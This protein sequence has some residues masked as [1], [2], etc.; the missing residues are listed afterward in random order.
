MTTYLNQVISGRNFHALK[1]IA[2]QT[3]QGPAC[4]VLEEVAYDVV[5]K[6]IIYLFLE[7]IPVGAPAG[8]N[9]LAYVGQTARETYDRWRRHSHKADQIVAL[10]QPIGLTLDKA[11][12]TV[13]GWM[14]DF[15]GKGPQKGPLGGLENI[16]HT[17][18][19]PGLPYCKG[20]HGVDF[21]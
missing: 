2:K 7:P 6:S 13:V 1:L 10:L 11:E 5:T 21:F 3:L 17:P 20:V 14:A 15:L 12:S 8:T 9:P 4:A 16:N 19:G 18:G